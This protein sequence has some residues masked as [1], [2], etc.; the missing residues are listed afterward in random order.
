MPLRRDGAGLRSRAAARGQ[1]LGARGLEVAR[2]IVGVVGPVA[3]PVHLGGRIR[4]GIVRLTRRPAG[5]TWLSGSRADPEGASHAGDT[6]EA[7]RTLRRRRCGNVPRDGDISRTRG[8]IVH[9]RDFV[10]AAR[11]LGGVCLARRVVAVG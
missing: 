11:V 10:C 7:V 1:A 3:V 8:T 4:V 5:G 9:Q 6:F 2:E